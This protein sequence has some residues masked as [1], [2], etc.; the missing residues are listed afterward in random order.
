MLA[1]F[2][3]GAV[4]LAGGQSLLIELHFRREAC[5]RRLGGNI[6][7]AGELD[8][9]RVCDGCGRR[10]ARWSGTG[11]LSGPDSMIRWRGCA[12]WPPGNVAPRHAGCE[13]TSRVSFCTRRTRSRPSRAAPPSTGGRPCA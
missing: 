10:S 1:E 3:A 5:T 8:Q 9:L 6:N 4:V 12:R 2:G 7:Q 13:G 11:S